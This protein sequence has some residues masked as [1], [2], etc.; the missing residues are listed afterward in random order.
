[1]D[2]NLGRFIVD[3]HRKKLNAI[4]PKYDY[5]TIKKY[6][7]VAKKIK[8][9][10]T[11]EAAQLLKKFYCELRVKDKAQNQNTSYRITVRQL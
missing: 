11:R 2:H 3:L 8:P 5:P 6:I 10:L 9:K 7:T 1:M 4:Q